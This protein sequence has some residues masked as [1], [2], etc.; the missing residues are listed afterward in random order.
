M[1]APPSDRSARWP[2]SARAPGKCIVFG[3]HG[4]VHGTPELLFA[5]DLETHVTLRASERFSL[6]GDV[7]ARHSHPYF[8]RAVDLLWPEGPPLAATA[9]S[10]IP[11]AAGLGSSAAFVAAFSVA[12][13]AEEDR[14]PSRLA[15]TS[16]QIE[17]GAQGVGSPGDTSAAVAGGFV[18]LN[19]EHGETLWTIREGR[20][21]WTVR[22][23][24][25][26]GWSWVVAYSGI[27][28]STAEAV[29]AVRERLALPDGS[30]LLDRFRQIAEEGMDAIT[31][32]DREAAGL[33]MQANQL[34][35]REVGV[36]HP[37]LEELLRSVEGLAAGAK[38]TGAGAGGSILVLPRPGRETAC[39]RRLARAG[40]L[41]FAVR[42]AP[43]GASPLPSPA[44]STE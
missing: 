24:L 40:A 29:R 35:L 2:R 31:R 37:R 19:A 16:F 43:T 39:L 1:S 17:H 26:P 14:L 44:G 11:K 18:S 10:R 36:S 28:R 6:N 7:E 25:D 12:L 33:A 32:E 9:T 30:S 38:L 15:E 4:V 8:Q 5:I 20:R 23:A 3:E 13:M 22:R 21:E 34:L 41:A 42:A 27:P